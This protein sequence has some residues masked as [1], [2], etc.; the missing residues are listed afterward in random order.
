MAIVEKVTAL[1]VSRP[2]GPGDGEPR[3]EI[4]VRVYDNVDDEEL[5]PQ[6]YVI[7]LTDQEKAQIRT[8][9]SNLIARR[10]NTKRP[11]ENI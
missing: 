7:A 6:S 9:L 8:F 5:K 10:A 2:T 1:I 11:L 3:A 4:Q